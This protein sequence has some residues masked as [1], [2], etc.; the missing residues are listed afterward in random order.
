L[1][2]AGHSLQEI[3]RKTKRPTRS[4]LNTGAER[5]IAMPDQETNAIVESTHTI[6]DLAHIKRL[7]NYYRRNFQ[8]GQSDECF[9]IWLE[10]GLKELRSKDEGQS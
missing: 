1:E 8:N 10:A 5:R 6:E 2:G 7:R 9:I 3:V 4:K